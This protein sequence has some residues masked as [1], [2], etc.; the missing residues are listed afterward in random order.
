MDGRWSIGEVSA[1]NHRFDG[2]PGEF[3]EWLR[4]ALEWINSLH[5]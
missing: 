4:E 2:N 3:Y 1:R 5:R